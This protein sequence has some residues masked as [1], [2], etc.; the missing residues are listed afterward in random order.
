MSYGLMKS[1][2]PRV[3]WFYLG[4]MDGYRAIA[5]DNHSLALY[6]AKVYPRSDTVDNQRGEVEW[7]GGNLFYDKFDFKRKVEILK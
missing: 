7:A 3:I 4:S 5:N 2:D 6:P 1:K